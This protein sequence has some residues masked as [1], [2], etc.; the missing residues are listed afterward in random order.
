ML[1]KTILF[2]EM[3]SVFAEEKHN[4]FEYYQLTRCNPILRN[5]PQN[6][7]KETRMK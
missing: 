2:P 3:H 5:V 4:F 1:V 7:L 6:D